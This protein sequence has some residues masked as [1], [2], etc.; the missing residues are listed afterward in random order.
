MNVYDV[1]CDLRPRTFG[2]VALGM[3]LWVVLFWVVLFILMPGLLLYS[4]GSG[5]N[6]V[7]VWI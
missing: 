2:Y 7:F 4:T 5:V 3:L 6:R 1:V